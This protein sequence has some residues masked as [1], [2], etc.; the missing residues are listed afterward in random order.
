MDIA[1]IGAL[2]SVEKIYTIL[3]SEY[4]DI[5]F[6]KYIDDQIKNLI[7]V[8]QTLEETIDGIIFTGG[9]VYKEI[10]QEI[11][12][13]KPF[14]YTQ[15]GSISLIKTIFN[16]L[17]EKKS[18]DNTSLGLDSVKEKDLLD[19]VDEFNLNPLNYILLDHRLYRDEKALAKKYIDL[20]E[21]GKIN[22]VFTGYKFIYNILEERNI[23]V[24]RIQ[25]TGME[26]KAMF[27]MLNNKIKLE[28]LGH[29]VIQ[30]QI[31]QI[32]DSKNQP[33]TNRIKDLEEDL[34]LY[35]REIEGLLHKVK[36][37]EYLIISNKGSGLSYKSLE[38]LFKISEKFKELNMLLAIGIGEG[39]TLVLSESNGRNAL[40][41]SILNRNSDI[42]YYNGE[43]VVGPLLKPEVISYKNVSEEEVLKLSKTIGIS[44][45]YIEKIISIKNKLSRSNFT[46][47]ELSNLLLISER[48][49]NR[50]LKKIID[51]GYGKEVGFENS[52]GS[53][54]PRRI[55]Q[56]NI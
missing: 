24:Y 27:N 50:I 43:K 22:C 2:D 26:I 39:Q 32:L 54:R 11:K 37:K 5:R 18:L 41:K 25:A 30:V 4:R 35:A 23:P 47:K 14:V 13:D 34:V 17:Q 55:I 9:G 20:Y 33:G 28:E 21:K 29:R 48:T 8:T 16:F 1:I 44:S 3:S 40:R 52:L 15:R 53:G 56:I 45:Q 46:S 36:D 49:A 10:S 31:I 6:H 51:S 38:S 19:L 7:Q 42:F 12:I